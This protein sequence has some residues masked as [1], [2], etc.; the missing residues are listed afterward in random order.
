MTENVSEL[1]NQ[2]TFI[3]DVNSPEV[4]QLEG[5]NMSDAKSSCEE[6]YRELKL[7]EYLPYANLDGLD[8][9]LSKSF[10]PELES[11]D[12][13]INSVDEFLKS[14]S[15]ETVEALFG[16]FKDKNDEWQGNFRI[17]IQK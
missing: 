10:W 15:K 1:L 5:K 6:I 8:E 17:F 2:Y 12:I 16:I 14:N 11:L 4:V 9:L 7:D 13:Q 3:S